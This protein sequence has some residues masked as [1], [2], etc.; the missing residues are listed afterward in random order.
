MISTL[1]PAA[2]AEPS[3]PGVAPGALEGA[4]DVYALLAQA[5]EIAA[6]A[7]LPPEAFAAAA[8]H[9]FLGASPGLAEHLAELQF[10]AALEELRKS[11]RLARA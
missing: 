3:Q 1:S 6:K 8:W 4:V 2:T 10:D 9:A 11:G 5:A 7:G